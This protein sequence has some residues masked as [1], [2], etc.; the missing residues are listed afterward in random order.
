MEAVSSWVSPD[1]LLMSGMSTLFQLSVWIRGNKVRRSCSVKTRRGRHRMKMGGL[2]SRHTSDPDRDAHRIG[3]PAQYCHNYL[4]EDV[5]L[6]VWGSYIIF[7]FMTLFLGLV[8]GMVLVFVADYLCPTKRQRPQGF[9]SPSECPHLPQARHRQNCTSKVMRDEQSALLSEIRS[10]IRE[11]V[12]ASLSSIVE[13]SSPIPSR[14][15]ARRERDL[16]E[17]EFS[18]ED[19]SDSEDFV[20]EEEGELP[21]GSQDHQR[22]CLFQAEETNDLVQAVRSTM[23]IEE[24]SKPQSRQD[25]MFGGL[26]SRRQ[27]VFPV[28]EHIKAMILEEWKEAE[29]RLVLSKDF[30]ARLPFEPEEVK[31][32]EEI[33]KVDDPV[34]MVAKRTAIPLENSSNLRDPMDRKADILLKRAWESSAALIKTNIAA[35]SVARSMYLWMGQFGRASVQ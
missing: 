3:P 10:L 19:K 12:Q 29:R 18:S 33:P 30:K 16:R 28:S 8:L 14:K 32:W 1:S 17:L 34:A 25:L 31:L 24:T 23:Q 7:G 22:K 35:T 11:E 4:V 5:G 13:K 26:M 9:S 2:G 15:R 21:S 27:T 20:S 6:P